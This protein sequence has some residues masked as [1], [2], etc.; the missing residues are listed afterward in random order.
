LDDI[1]AT[2]VSEAEKIPLFAFHEPNKVLANLITRR[3]NEKQDRR[4]RLRE[5]EMAKRIV[6][7]MSESLHSKPKDTLR[8]T[9]DKRK[10]RK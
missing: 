9:P 5:L 8:V 4:E 2:G 10:S 7:A 6:L 3:T 1:R